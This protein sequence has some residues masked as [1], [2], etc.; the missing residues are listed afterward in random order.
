MCIEKDRQW[1]KLDTGEEIKKKKKGLNLWLPDA[2][3]N[4]L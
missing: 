2:A 4:T 1:R 3:C